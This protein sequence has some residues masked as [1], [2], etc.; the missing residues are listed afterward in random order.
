[1]GAPAG[2][3]A[4]PPKVLYAATD[5]GVLRSTDG[6]VHWST[7]NAGLWLQH[8]LDVKALV[9]HPADAHRI[10]ALPSRGGIFE[11][12]FTGAE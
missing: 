10:F 5:R 2:P 7:V 8:R 11:A 6:G 1:M 4:H 12:R 3:R 9:A